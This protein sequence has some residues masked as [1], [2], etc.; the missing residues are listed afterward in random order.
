VE[1]LKI[2][3]NNKNFASKVAL[4]DFFGVPLSKDLNFCLNCPKFQPILE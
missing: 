1:K 2:G 4:I 3:I